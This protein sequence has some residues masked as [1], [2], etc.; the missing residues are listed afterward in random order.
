[1]RRAVCLVA[2]LLA[3]A[4]ALA[5]A[6]PAATTAVDIS[7]RSAGTYYVEGEIA[8]IGELTMLVDTGSSYLVINEVM[9]EKLIDAG[10]AE[11][12]R[13]LEGRMADGST[14]LTPLYRLSGVRLGNGCWVH[15]VEAAVFPAQSRPIL[16]MNV[17]MQLAPFTFSV[18]PAQLGFSNCA[19]PPVVQPVVQPVVEPAVQPVEAGEE[20]AANVEVHGADQ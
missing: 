3:L 18:A 11:F 17:L 2:W 12:S 6:A 1:M 15:D 16:G 19:G 9:L 5:G 10:R 4:P 20:A 8:G 14:R 7:L 13:R